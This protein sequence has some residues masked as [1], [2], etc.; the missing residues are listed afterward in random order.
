MSSV[1]GDN[2]YSVSHVH[3]VG[4]I[5]SD[6]FVFPVLRLALCFNIYKY[7]WIFSVG[8]S[9]EVWGPSSDI[10]DA[11]SISFCCQSRFIHSGLDRE[12]E[13]LDATSILKQRNLVIPLAQSPFLTNPKVSSPSDAAEASFVHQMSAVLGLGFYFPGKK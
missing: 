2:Y 12:K 9:S 8:I 1:R 11:H 7:F 6:A 13:E 5:L 3:D 10:S 4:I